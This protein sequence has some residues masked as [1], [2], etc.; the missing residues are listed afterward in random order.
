MASV[1]E[2]S[3]KVQ[4][5]MLDSNLLYTVRGPDHFS[6]R[7]ESVGVFVRVWGR[8]T[9]DDQRTFINFEVPILVGVN[10]SPE[11]YKYIALHADDYIFGHLSLTKFEDGQLA[12]FFTHALLGDY[13]DAGEFHAVMASIVQTSDRL[14]DE[15]QPQFGGRR[16]HESN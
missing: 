5:M 1:A 15:L 6:L 14:D 11:L 13:L 16:F 4:A 3:S 7:F 10:D 2:V 12:I 8:D 9:E